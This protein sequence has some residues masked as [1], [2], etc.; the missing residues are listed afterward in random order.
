VPDERRLFSLVRLLALDID[1]T[2]TD[3]RTL[4]LGDDV[5]WVQSYSVR[6][7]ESIL[8]LVAH[9]IPVVPVSR[10]KTRCAR[11]RMQLLG[12]PIDWLAVADKVEAIRQVSARFAIAPENICYVGDGPEDVPVL[13]LVGI[14]CS[15]RDG[16]PEAVRAAQFV[17]QAVGGA[18]AIAE[19]VQE[20]LS[21]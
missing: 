7:G 18:H 20:I 13:R 4:W 1:G 16:S 11:E 10:N 9:G 2:L 15:V 5:G 8:R 6:D 21:A 12:L 3:G 17:T 14:P 19:I